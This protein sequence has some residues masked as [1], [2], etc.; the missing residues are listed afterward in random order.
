MKWVVGLLWL[1]SVAAAPHPPVTAVPV[2][3]DTRAVLRLLGGTVDLYGS[4]FGSLEFQRGILDLARSGAV[5]NFKALKSLGAEIY[6]VPATFKNAM[7]FVQGGVGIVLVGSEYH[8]MPAQMA[9]S[10]QQHLNMY[11]RSAVRF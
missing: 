5:Q 10:A 7:I 8:V 4:S 6:V 3:S 2:T 9:A 11:W 1:G